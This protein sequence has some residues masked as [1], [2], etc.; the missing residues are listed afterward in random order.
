METVAIT[1]VEKVSAIPVGYLWLAFLVVMVVTI[2]FSFILRYHWKMLDT[3]T[4]VKGRRVYWAGIILLILVAISAL[5]VFTNS[6]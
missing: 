4:V 2:I 5:L 6:K 3:K 1:L